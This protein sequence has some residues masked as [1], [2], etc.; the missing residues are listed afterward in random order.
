MKDFWKTSESMV[1]I[2]MITNKINDKKYIGQSKNVFKRWY[3]H[4]EESILNRDCDN[5]ILHSAIRIYGIENFEFSIVELCEI[6]ELDERE[7][8]YISLYETNVKDGGYNIANGG[9][10][11]DNVGENN[12]SSKLSEN[13]IYYIREMY[14]NK[15][16]KKEVYNEF[17]NVISMSTFSDIWNGRTWQH[18]HM[19]VYTDE[20][21]QYQKN[22]FDRITSHPRKVSNED[23]LKIRNLYNEG[24]LS[25]FEIYNMFSYINQNTF[26]DI[27]FNRTFKHIQS[28]ITNKRKKNIRPTINQYG[29]KNPSAIFSKED[30]ILIRNRRDCGEDMVKVYEDYKHLCVKQTFKNIWENKTY[31]NANNNR[32]E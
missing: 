14:N 7:I 22:N 15:K 18:I 26:N 32:E 10:V 31:K 28:D 30:I 20:N 9:A 8:F 27:W 5:S 19:D 23:V 3:Q 6:S 1:G 21:K 11:P 12:S 16:T 4:Y 17:S 25:K 2:Y 13:D 24:V 29:H